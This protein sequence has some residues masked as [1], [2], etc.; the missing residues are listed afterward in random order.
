MKYVPGWQKKERGHLL[1]KY[2]VHLFNY[3]LNLEGKYKIPT[4]MVH[5]NNYEPFI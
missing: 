1:D 3:W 2:V 5:P 4:E